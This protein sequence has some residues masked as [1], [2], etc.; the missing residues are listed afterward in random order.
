[1]NLNPS[2]EKA[3][4]QACN[5]SLTL[6]QGPPGTGKS[7]TSASIIKEFLTQ[8]GEE[9]ILAVAETN[10]GVDNL[11]E[12]IVQVFGSD[13]PEGLILRVGSSTWSVRESLQKFTLEARYAERSQGK[14]VRENWMDKK[15]MNKILNEARVVCT[16]CSSAGSKIFDETKFCKLLVDEASQATEPAILVPV[17]RGTNYSFFIPHCMLSLLFFSSLFCVWLLLR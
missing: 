4:R 10:E 12:K 16:T 11:L 1:M 13:L 9:K 8:N 17:S 5:N 14:R 7:K 2:Q 6:I 15:I 3:V